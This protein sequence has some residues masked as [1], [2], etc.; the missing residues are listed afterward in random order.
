V[1]HRTSVGDLVPVLPA[2]AGL[3]VSVIAF[4]SGASVLG[5]A[6]GLGGF[7]LMIVLATLSKGE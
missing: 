2:L 5:L 6:S 3:V 7:L 4:R 1:P